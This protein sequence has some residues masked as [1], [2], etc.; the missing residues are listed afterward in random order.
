MKLELDGP[1]EVAFADLAHMKAAMARSRIPLAPTR[2]TRWWV[3]RDEFHAVAAV[4]G[5]I[6]IAGGG[7]RIKAVWVRPDQRHRG[8]ATVMIEHAVAV[9]EEAC[10][11][12][13]EA[14]IGPAGRPLYEARR[15]RLH[16]QRPNGCVVVRRVL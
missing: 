16:G 12:Y 1:H 8:V 3:M 15:F 2:D 11:S 14:I 5:L 7:M 4:H 6:R 13:V 10:A 9:A